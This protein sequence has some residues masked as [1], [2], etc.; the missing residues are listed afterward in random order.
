[1]S[2]S[3]LII[4]PSCIEKFGPVVDQIRMTLQCTDDQVL[5][6]IDGM[7]AAGKTTL[8]YYLKQIFQ[9]NLFH[10]D[11]FFLTQQLRTPSRLVEIGGNVDYER[12]FL[13]VIRPIQGKKSVIYRPYSCSLGKIEG[14]DQI[15]YERLN[16]IEGSY[17]LH[18]FFMEPYHLKFFMSISDEEQIRRVKL[19]NGEQMLARFQGEWIPK[20]NAYFEH[21]MIRENSIVI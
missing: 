9:C 13:E 15:P 17:S 14:E 10:M 2:E 20:E 5:V 11:D 7:C 19:R 6:G 3:K 16:I 4:N 21:F 1:M 8:G 12:F 18:P